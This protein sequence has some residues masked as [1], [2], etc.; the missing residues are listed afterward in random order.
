ME[1]FSQSRWWL[2]S[3]D[4]FVSRPPQSKNVFLYDNCFKILYDQTSIKGIYVDPKDDLTCFEYT[5]I[6]DEQATLIALQHDYRIGN[7]E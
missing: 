6:S 3:T 1:M 5:P 4:A 7:H 2:W